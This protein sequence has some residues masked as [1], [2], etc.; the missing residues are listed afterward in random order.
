MIF[1]KDNINTKLAATF[2]LPEEEKKIQRK[3]PREPPHL[4]VHD[5]RRLP[6]RLLSASRLWGV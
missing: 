4:V 3:A 1:G 6:R 5:A 2:F